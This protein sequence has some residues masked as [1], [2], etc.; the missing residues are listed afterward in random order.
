MIEHFQFLQCD[1]VGVSAGAPILTE[2]TQP[3]GETKYWEAKTSDV[4]LFG[5]SV[6]CELVGYGRTPEQA[7][8]RL[9]E[10]KIKLS[11]TLWE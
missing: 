1:H 7:L 11:E 9:E 8:L 10:E 2:K 3:D 5:S 4:A 6:C